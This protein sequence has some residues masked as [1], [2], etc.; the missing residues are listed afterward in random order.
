MKLPFL[1]KKE[2]PEYF[3]ALVLRNEKAT[4]VIFEK[5]GTTIKYISHGEEEFKNTVEDAE[6]EEFLD[7]LDKTITQ[8]ESALP[9]NIETH[10]TIF[11]LK[12]SWIENNKI[13]K[14][15]L[16]KL[17][18]AST[19]LS[20][21][22][23]GFLVFAESII[24]LVQKDEGAPV[25]AVLADIGNKFITVSLIK[26]GRVMETKS[27]EI[28]ENA[29]YTVDALLKHFQT[30]EVMPARIILFDSE[31]E[32]LTQEFMNHQWSKSLP[33]L[34]LP[35]IVSLP[36]DATIKAMLLG[37]ATQMGT[38]L[39]YDATSVDMDVDEVPKKITPD[40]FTENQPLEVKPEEAPGKEE[41]TVEET[42][43]KSEEIPAQVTAPLDYVDH[44]D[45]LEYFGFVENSDIAKVPTPEPLA[46]EE[47]VPQTVI[48]EATDEIP[49]EQ[50]IETEKKTGLPAIAALGFIKFKKILNVLLKQAKQIKF[51]GLLAKVK[52]K[53]RKLLIIPAVIIVLLVLM[54]G[55]FFLNT[56]ATVS[57]LINPK[58]DSKTASVTFSASSATDISNSVLAAQTISV[59][60]DG[61]VTETA[62]GKKDI[63]TAAKGAVTIFN[64]ATGN[65][66]LPSGTTITA[67]NGLQ[68]TL[69]SAVTVASGDAIL[70]A[71]TA[72]ANVTAGD[73][74]Q[75]YNLPSGT[76]FTV[77]GQ[78]SSVA[79]KND[80][81]F[82]GGTKKSVTVVSQ[83]DIQ[84]ALTDLP[85]QLEGKA[86]SDIAPKV[87]DGNAL[88]PNFID[89]N[90]DKQNFDKKLNDQANQIILQGTV[91]FQGIS[92]SNAD[93]VKLANLLF[94]SGDTQLGQNDLGISAKNIVVEKNNDVSA[95]LTIQANLVPKIDTTALGKQIAGSSVQKAKNL[96]S[97]F[98][99]VENVGIV[100][101]PDLPFLPKNLPGNPKN[102][103]IGITTK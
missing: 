72:T 87:T 99:Q 51:K 10:K 8:A 69:D 53:D 5:I 84:K 26:S 77:S 23:I 61:S 91:T 58:Q 19:D 66:V 21:D 65:L 78:D 67:P 73:I 62:T 83:N 34:H 27:S 13:K 17:K 40:E 57:I 41:E 85:K 7:V 90:V 36:K 54:L 38:K 68:F 33:F 42:T 22:P 49:E 46:E 43:V 14:E 71:S 29:P 35:Q 12:E 25:T 9:E 102:I 16:E 47:P 98:P 60:E 63:G 103:R 32:E 50:K 1:E 45:S 94:N 97:N 80:N 11:G 31:E 64:I 76:K 28:H 18:K 44:D 52:D 88:L 59:S 95:D 81:A 6:T 39:L 4:S 30:P 101:N 2:K 75:D 74:G 82:S 96:I 70:G 15:Y 55:L 37:A 24:N 56:K 20:L 48:E 86:R 79:A 3:L 100:L 93:M 89:E 92:Y